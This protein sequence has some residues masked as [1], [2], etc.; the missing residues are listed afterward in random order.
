MGIFEAAYAWYAV[1]AVVILFI[2]AG[3]CF[4]AVKNKKTKKTEDAA[5]VKTEDTTVENTESSDK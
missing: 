4:I 3:A 5:E 1:A 2:C